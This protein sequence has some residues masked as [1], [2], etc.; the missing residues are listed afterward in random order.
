MLINECISAI[1]KASIKTYPCF[2]KDREKCYISMVFPK[3]STTHNPSG[4]K[5]SLH[6][7]KKHKNCNG[8][9]MS[10]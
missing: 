4:Y 10:N 9:M 2:I 1:M 6:Y 8:S 5:A 3:A 7:A